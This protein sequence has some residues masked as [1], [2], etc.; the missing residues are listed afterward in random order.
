MYEEAEN[1]A[2]IN[3]FVLIFG[4]TLNH[5]TEKVQKKKADYK[6]IYGSGCL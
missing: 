4:K 1:K 3:S 6:C 5:L 2:T